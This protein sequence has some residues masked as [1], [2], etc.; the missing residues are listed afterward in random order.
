LVAKGERILE[1]EMREEVWVWFWYICWLYFSLQSTPSFL[2]QYW[3]TSCTSPIP[4]NF[5]VT[6]HHNIDYVVM[7]I[8]LVLCN[9]VC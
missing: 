7:Q 8:Y 4:P 6:N 9:L 3:Y 2:Q 1:M 5:V